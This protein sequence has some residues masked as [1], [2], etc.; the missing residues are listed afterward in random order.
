MNFQTFVWINVL[1]LIEVPGV[2]VGVGGAG[3]GG[4]FPGWQMLVSYF[5][6]SHAPNGFPFDEFLNTNPDSHTNTQ[7]HTHSQRGKIITKQ[8]VQGAQNQS[9][10]N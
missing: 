2:G 6:H 8:K 4:L 5:M 3:D 1:P 9:V 10:V 7:P